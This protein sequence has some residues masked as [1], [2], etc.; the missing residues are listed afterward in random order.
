[1]LRSLR[2]QLVLIIAFLLAVVV[3]LTAL[4]FWGTSTAT[5]HFERSDAAHKSLEDYV[6]L[7]L[8]SYRYFKKF[9]YFA[10]SQESAEVR[11][12]SESRRD[13]RKRLERL[14][15][16]TRR[17]IDA[18]PDPTERQ[19]EAEELVRIAKI[20]GV[21]E[22]IFTEFDEIRSMQLQDQLAEASMVLR[23][24]RDDLIAGEFRLLI[25]TATLEEQ[26][27]AEEADRQAIMLL[28]GLQRSVLLVSVAT[29][30]WLPTTTLAL[31][32]IGD[33]G[34]GMSEEDLELA[35][36]RFYRGERAR[37][38]A[39]SGSGLGLPLAKAIVEAHQGKISISSTEGAGTKVTISL[40]L[41][42]HF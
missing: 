23:R 30:R 29:V 25:D 36:E 19:I 41:I 17:E 28:E 21:L 13:L 35:F 16:H 37:E 10:L 32:E 12:L 40:P 15:Q 22:G 6:F 14:K 1:M 26:R 31:V 39:P 18:I 3:A 42:A 34:I 33:D 7:S 27:E 9:T 11:V 38:F 24:T 8:E 5:R 2:A 20:E 4:T